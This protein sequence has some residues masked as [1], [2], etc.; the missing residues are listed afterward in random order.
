M[1]K[2]FR[3]TSGGIPASDCLGFRALRGGS[4]SLEKD[5]IVRAWTSR[6]AVS[7]GS[8]RPGTDFVVASLDACAEP[9]AGSKVPDPPANTESTACPAK[10]DPSPS[11]ASGAGPGPDSIGNSP[12]ASRRAKPGEQPQQ[13][14]KLKTPTAPAAPP[15][16]EHKPTIESYYYP[17]QSAHSCQHFASAHFFAHGRRLRR[18]R[19]GT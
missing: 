14:P 8:S 16:E 6:E 15:P 5:E 1:Q 13:T 9:P 2:Y 10:A 11:K 17:R 4:L 18:K 7:A 3:P 19:P 12:S